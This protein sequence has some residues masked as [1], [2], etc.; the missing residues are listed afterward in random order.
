MSFQKFWL[1]NL[2][3]AMNAE[4]SGQESSCKCDW[5]DS[6][7][8]ILRTME[9]EAA[10][11]TLAKCLQCCGRCCL[12][13]EIVST[14]K[15]YYAESGKDL[16]K[17]LTMLNQEGIGGGSMRQQ[18]G[19]I[20]ASYSAC[21]CPNAQGETELP[22]SYCNCSQGWFMELFEG[23]LGHPVKVIVEQSIIR[24]ADQCKFV[25]YP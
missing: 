22:Y 7:P 9:T 17:L 13:P 3:R 6:I 19:K 16:D 25:I 4:C 8:D 10:P 14:A 2:K 23:V 1:G 21:Y 18:D 15:T 24:G 11:E 20:Y 12:D 5:D